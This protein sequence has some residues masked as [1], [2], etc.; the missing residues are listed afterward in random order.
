[1]SDVDEYIRGEKLKVRESRT[2]MAEVLE[3]KAIY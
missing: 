2:Q 3:E 1:M